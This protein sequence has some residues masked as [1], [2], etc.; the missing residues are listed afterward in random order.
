ML[1]LCNLTVGRGEAG[2][3]KDPGPRHSASVIIVYLLIHK[4][5]WSRGR[6]T[7][8]WGRDWSDSR[9]R[10]SCGMLLIFRRSYLGVWGGWD[11]TIVANVC[12]VQ[13]PS[14]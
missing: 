11:F 14:G 1:T 3:I 7:G 4:G 12:H 5:S 10:N 2:Y 6:F 8:G 13:D 9:Q